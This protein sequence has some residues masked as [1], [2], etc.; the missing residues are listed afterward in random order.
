MGSVDC[1]LVYIIDHL[2]SSR[3]KTQ[4]ISDQ[5]IYISSPSEP[6]SIHTSLLLVNS[7]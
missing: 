6:E 2:L 5:I 4:A 1:Y 3:V 7:L